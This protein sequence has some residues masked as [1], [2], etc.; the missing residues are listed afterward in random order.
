MKSLYYHIILMMLLLVGQVAQA[1]EYTVQSV[2]NVQVAD[3]TQ[4]V[5]DPDNYLGADAK[6]H[7]NNMLVVSTCKNSCCGCLRPP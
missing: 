4:Y 3:R 2:P 6:A 7:I 5:S 1:K